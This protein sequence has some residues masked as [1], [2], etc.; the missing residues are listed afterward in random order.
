MK[1]INSIL[2]LVAQ[3]CVTLC[4]P[5]DY[6]S[7]GSSDHGI[8][9]ARILEWVAISSSRGSSPPRDWTQVSCIA[10]RFLTIW[11]TMGAQ[12]YWSGWHIPSPGDLPDPRIKPGSLA[13]QADSL[14]A[15]YQGSSINSILLSKINLVTKQYVWYLLF[16]K[17]YLLN[18]TCFIYIY[19]NHFL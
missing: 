5:V 3:S 4:D 11:A 1:L 15:E 17:L 2:R 12:E 18:K 14:L 8:L 9:Q 10:G 19:K 7:P 13:L 6:S 16:L